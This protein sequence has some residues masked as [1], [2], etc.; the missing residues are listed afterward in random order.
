MDVTSNLL[1]GFSVCILSASIQRG[2]TPEYLKRL[3]LQNSGTIVENPLLNNPTCFV[4]AGDITYRVKVLSTTKKYDIVS[5]DWF[6]RSCEKQ[7][8]IL[9]PR[10]MLAMTPN[11]EQ[12]F[13]KFYDKWGDN[14]TEFV[15]LKELKRVCD[16]IKDEDVPDL[17]ANE[18]K[19]LDELIYKNV[20]RNWFRT[21]YAYFYNM[22]LASEKAKLHYQ[23]HGGHV[24]DDRNLNANDTDCYANVSYI[25]INLEQVDKTTFLIWLKERFSENLQNLQII[26]IEWILES[27]T[28]RILQDI[29]EYTWHDF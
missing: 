14:Y 10:D 17:D 16:H 23:W 6:L 21:K 29:K 19:E 25:F 2:Y 1:K 13:A 11:L 18:L 4:V 15:S 22:D 20:N 9:K 28:A 7:K 26:S 24:L 8:I 27:H 5:M 3:V 12:H